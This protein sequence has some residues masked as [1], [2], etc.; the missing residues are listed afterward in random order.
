ML[1]KNT[2]WSTAEIPLQ[3]LNNQFQESKGEPIMG[4]EITPVLKSN[5]FWKSRDTVTPKKSP[6]T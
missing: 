3:K 5:I 6:E 1:G 2:W 4:E